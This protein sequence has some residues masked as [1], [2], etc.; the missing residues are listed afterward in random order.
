MGQAQ[1]KTENIMLIDPGEMARQDFTGQVE[2][3]LGCQ[4]L[5]DEK[6]IG[7]HA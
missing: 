7:V 6:P 2:S 4:I 5:A 1:T 3:T